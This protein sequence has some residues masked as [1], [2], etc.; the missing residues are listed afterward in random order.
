[1]PT[2]GLGTW[3]HQGAEEMKEAV[4]Y[5]HKQDKELFTKIKQCYR[6]AIKN[7][8]RHIDGAHIYLNEEE[9][10]DIYKEMIDSR[11]VKRR[12]LFIASKVSY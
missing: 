5:I 7:G 3:H 4:R 1:M 12:D 6:F 2:V 8:Y 11:Q 9:M 10:G